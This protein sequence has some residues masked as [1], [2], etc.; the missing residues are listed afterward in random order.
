M[1]IKLTW[2]NST[3]ASIK[4]MLYFNMKKKKKKDIF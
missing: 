1:Q 2:E 3:K 4:K